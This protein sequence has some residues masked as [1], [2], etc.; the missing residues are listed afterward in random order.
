MK[1]RQVKGNNQI[2]TPHNKESQQAKLQWEAKETWL[3][4]HCFSFLAAMHPVR[5]EFDGL[6]ILIGKFRRTVKE[7]S[8]L[9][10]VLV[11]LSYRTRNIREYAKTW[12]V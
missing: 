8:E 9:N 12:H 7:S 5:I 1:E 2:M 4:L 3:K 11:P 6:I 10:R